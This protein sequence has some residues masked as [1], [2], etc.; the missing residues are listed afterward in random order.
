MLISDKISHKK[1]PLTGLNSQSY[2]FG[3]TFAFISY[4]LGP[5]LEGALWELHNSLH[6]EN[7]TI[8]HYI[9]VSKQKSDK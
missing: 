3:I 2:N 1:H 6:Y 8:H 9:A 7:W 4:I 5:Q